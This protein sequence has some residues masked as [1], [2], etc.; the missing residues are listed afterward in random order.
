MPDEN[1][2]NKMVQAPFD[3]TASLLVAAKLRIVKT[4]DGYAFIY[5]LK[6][7]P[8]PLPGCVLL[9]ISLYMLY[10]MITPGLA[11]GVSALLFFFFLFAGVYLIAGGKEVVTVNS[12]ALFV[13]DRIVEKIVPLEEISFLDCQK[14]R[15]RKSRFFHQIRIVCKTSKAITLFNFLEPEIAEAVRSRL[16]QCIF[17][18]KKD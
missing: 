5:G 15:G 13:K 2:T 16:H 14:V 10:R 12:Q 8:Q 11:S 17:A 6:K 4:D 7:K 3:Y 18:M 1:D 9:F